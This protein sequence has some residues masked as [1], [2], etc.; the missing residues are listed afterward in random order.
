MR[1]V[2][3]GARSISTLFTPTTNYQASFPN[4]NDCGK[5]YTNV[6]WT[7]RYLWAPPYPPGRCRPR[8]T[9]ALG[10]TTMPSTKATCT[11]L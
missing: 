10:G 1:R 7:H 5:L 3:G 11:Y 2:V 9:P 6:F 4:P 8:A